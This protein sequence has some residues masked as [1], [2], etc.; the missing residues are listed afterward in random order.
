MRAA[1]AEPAAHLD[2]LDALLAGDAERFSRLTAD[3]ASVAAFAGFVVHHQVAVPLLRGI[4][5][6]GAS[7]ALPALLLERLRRRAEL[8]RE[9]TARLVALHERL[10]EPLARRGIAYLLLKGPVLSRR[11]YGALDARESVDLDLLVG[12]ADARRAGRALGEIGLTRR[13]RTPWSAAVVARFVHALDYDSPEGA[14][15]LHWVLDRHPSLRL[16]AE[17]LWR[18]ARREP[19]GGADVAV[20]SDHGEILAAC[21]GAVRDGERGRL[22]LKSLLDLRR[23]MELPHS[24]SGFLAAA[25]AQRAARPCLRALSLV[26]AAFGLPDEPPVDLAAAWRQAQ[27]ASGGEEALPSLLAG[28][29]SWRARRWAF[30]SW[31]SSP[32]ASAA[33]WLLSL[34]FRLAV[35]GRQRPPVR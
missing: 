23:W 32:A 3:S 6:A 20:P 25:R 11:L 35:H 7:G 28:L 19:L 34:P 29:P 14:V 31:E 21:L 1:S 33:W 26:A 2:R 17:R 30:A 4:E 9:R 5:R 12:A 10:R 24:W 13:M 18:E 16:D 27:P 22:K 15:D 8:Q